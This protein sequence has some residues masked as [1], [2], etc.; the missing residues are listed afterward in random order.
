M[1]KYREHFRLSI[2]DLELIERAIRVEM[3]MH[4]LVE[5]EHADFEVARQKSRELDE[6][7]GKLFNQ[8]VFYSQVNPTGVPVA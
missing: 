7:L 1:A 2:N 6:V 5:P 8:K 3:S 4:A